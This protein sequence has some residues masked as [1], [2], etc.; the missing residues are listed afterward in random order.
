MCAFLFFLIPI[1]IF[2]GVLVYNCTKGNTISNVWTVDN[3]YGGL[4]NKQL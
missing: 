2:G 1:V 4:T 3:K